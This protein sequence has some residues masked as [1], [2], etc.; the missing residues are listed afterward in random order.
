MEV[1]DARPGD[2]DRLVELIAELGFKVDE[3][4]V[5]ER[6]RVLAANGEPVIVAEDQGRLVGMLDWH[7]MPTIH[8]PRPVGRIVALVVGETSRGIG[9]GTA[10]VREAEGRMRARGCEKMEVTSNLRLDRAHSFYER[11][12]LERS[13]YRFAKEL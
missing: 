3:S 1:R 8:R 12:G 5:A 2:A 4:G 6:L 7:V 11:Y 10:L 9:I 13:S